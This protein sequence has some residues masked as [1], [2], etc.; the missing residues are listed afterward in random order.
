VSTASRTSKPG[1]STRTRTSR[2]ML[3]MPVALLRAK[4][5]MS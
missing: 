5:T 1:R 2:R 4:T 3:K